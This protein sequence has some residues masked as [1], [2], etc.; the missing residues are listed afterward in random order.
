[1]TKNIRGL[2]KSPFSRLKRSCFRIIILMLL[3]M[4]M[5]PSCVAPERENI[6]V[7]T[8]NIRYDNPDDGL[9]NWDSRKEMVF[10]MIEKYDPDILGVQEALDG[11]M[12][13]LDEALSGYR[14]SGAGRDDGDCKG[15]YVPVFYKKDRFMLADEGHFWLSDHPEQPGSMGWDAACTRMVSWINLK[16]ISTGYDYYVF[17]THFD[18]IGEEARKN[19]ARLLSDSIRSIAMLKPI[20]I[21]G[22]FN[23]V[24]DSEP[25]KILS[26]LFTDAR[27]QVIEEDTLAGTTFVGFPAD[28]NTE[29]IID[30]I[31]ISPHFLVDQYEIVGDNANGFFPSD[32]LPVRVSLA[33]RMP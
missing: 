33:L 9:F 11:Q 29:K 23:C 15:E 1:M 19:S 17:N 13:E 5:I 20:I 24:S 26:E 18:H 25:M 7:M 27:S 10:W 2:L 31:F 4:F 3:A 21:T 8:F 30:H 22:D 6:E 28:M 12:N 32:H 14:W 16:E